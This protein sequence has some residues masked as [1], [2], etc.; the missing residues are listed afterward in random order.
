M[1]A[2][3]TRKYFL[4]DCFRPRSTPGM[5]STCHISTNPSLRMP[6]SGEILITPSLW[7]ACPVAAPHHPVT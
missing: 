3:S 6:L 7:W 2:R 1:C 4:Y 5:D